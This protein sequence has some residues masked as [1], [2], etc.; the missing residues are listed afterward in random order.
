MMIFL[1]LSEALLTESVVR[2]SSYSLKG[3]VPM[4]NLVQLISLHEQAEKL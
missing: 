1:K 3:I 4:I 2:W